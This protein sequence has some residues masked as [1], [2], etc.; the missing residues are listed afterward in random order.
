VTPII[1]RPDQVDVEQQIYASW[2]AGHR[3]VLAVAATGWGKTIVI[4]EVALKKHLLGSW[5]VKI[6]HRNELC[7]QLSNTIARRGI[8][9]R[10]IASASTVRQITAAHRR[11]FGRS[12]VNPDAPC[13]VAGI[14]T[15]IARKDQLKSWAQQI[16][17]W[18]LDEAHHAAGGNK[19]I[20]GIEMFPN[21]VGLGVTGSPRRAD[22][23]GLGR[24][25]S[26]GTK[27]DGIFDTMVLAPD[28][29]SL[30][31]MG[32]LCDYEIAIP[33]TDFNVD[34]SDFNKDGELSPA[35]GRLASQKSQI[36]GDVVKEY[37][38]RAYGKR[39]ICF[40]TDVVTAGEIAE[41]F[42]SVGIIAASV[43]AKTPSDVRDEYIRRF[44]EGKIT[45][46]VNVDLFGEGFDV[47]AVEVVI[48]ARPTG[49]L[50]VYL[51]QF[52]RALR[53]LNGKLYGLIIDHVSNWKRH[54]FPDKAHYWS[55][56][57]RD[58][59][60]KKDKDPEE[61]ELT[62]CKGCGRPYEKFKPKCPKC[63]WSPPLP[64]AGAGRTIEMVD[65][66]L[67]LMD[68]ATCER[69]RQATILESP[70]SAA[71]R[72]GAVAGPGAH[73]GMLNRQIEKHQAQQR[74]S[75]A[76]A[77]WAAIQRA[78]G[79]S[80]DESYRR[81]Y[82]TLGMD[83]MSALSAQHSRADFEAMAIKVEGWFS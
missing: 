2:N 45:M 61:I 71:E 67:T 21:A 54:G 78:K 81:I 64:E 50:A 22:G 15:L 70:A 43:S 34:E 46:L 82:H 69:M 40:A 63:G 57:R 53:L 30:I 28:M 10:I 65:G 20:Q 39:G 52:G 73:A 55:L 83:M 79:R 5:Q 8:P 75:L 11:E 33:S 31:D 25:Q 80:D 26:D 66:D 24:F 48:M 27:G 42:N 49:S 1:L 13:A 17:H 37:I 51:Q 36:V 18:T 41:R 35:K 23:Q 19:W 32:A 76:F 12:L 47:P 62:Q 59:R 9:H 4:S 68:R 14:D 77:Q 44:R 7:G 6:A 38:A 60:G 3:N 16:D 56:D 29:R 58:K 74:L 72:A